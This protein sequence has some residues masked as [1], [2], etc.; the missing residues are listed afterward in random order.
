MT[1][2]G[3]PD[4]PAFS[5]VCAD[6]RAAAAPD[7]VARAAVMGAFPP[8][9]DDL[10]CA[11]VHSVPF[12]LDPVHAL[13]SRGRVSVDVVDACTHIVAADVAGVA[14]RLCSDDAGAV[15]RALSPHLILP[16]LAVV[17][18]FL[19]PPRSSAQDAVAA[20]RKLLAGIC[21]CSESAPRGVVA[22][23]RL[24]RA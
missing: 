11:V 13:H 21:G 8:G 5:A 17:R 16:D 23:A 20:S 18:L 2:P 22:D 19:V 6:L 10:A 12:V 14:A 4:V 9:A 7:S 1:P 24:G 15:L 3:L